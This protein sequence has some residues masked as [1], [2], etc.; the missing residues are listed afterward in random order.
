MSVTLSW[1]EPVSTGGRSREELRYDIWYRLVGDTDT[2]LYGTA[3][4]T[5]GEIK[6]MSINYCTILLRKSA[7]N[8]HNYTGLV[9]GAVYQLLVSSE[10]DITSQSPA[11]D[12]D[13]RRAT[14]TFQVKNSQNSDPGQLIV[15]VAVAVSAVGVGIVTAVVTTLAAVCAAVKYHRRRLQRNEMISVTKKKLEST[16]ELQ[17][18]L[19]TATQLHSDLSTYDNKVRD[20]NPGSEDPDSEDDYEIMVTNANC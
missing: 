16:M 2:T 19:K 6:G 11:T 14:V 1:D 17:A 12:L 5:R 9:S 8:N 20:F 18:P 10:T 13:R 7:F 4:T 15:G 3:N